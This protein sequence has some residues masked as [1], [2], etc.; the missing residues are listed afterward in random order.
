[1]IVWE[2]HIRIWRLLGAV[3]AVPAGVAGTYGAYRSYVSNGVSCTELRGSII[4]TLERN[5]APDTK[6]ALLR[7][8]VE[9]FDKYCGEKDPAARAI[10]DAA[11]APPPAASPGPATTVHASAG[12]IFGLSKTGERRGW[13][14]LLRRDA[15]RE[16]IPSFD[17]GGSPVSA[18]S[19]PALGSI[20]K[21][22]RLV[23][24]WLEP[25][26]V[27]DPAQLQGQLA[28]GACVRILTIRP[29]T[30][31]LWAEVAPDACQ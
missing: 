23:P 13:V 9:E 24:V 30:P 12:A 2:K 19:P 6:R 8:S 16:D 1:M 20:V 26:A 7:G 5:I 28:E 15:N 22:R 21:A 31:R 14:A 11:I 4:A 10:F 18:G 17:S 29:A 27:N 3:L 25:Q